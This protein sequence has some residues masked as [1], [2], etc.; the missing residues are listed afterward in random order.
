M[1]GPPGV[2]REFSGAGFNATLR[3]FGRIGQMMLDEGVA[4]GRRIVPAQWVRESTQPSGQRA[5][6][7]GGY[8]LQW[9]MAD[10]EGAYMAIG[11]QGQ[12]LYV[13][14]ASRT[15]IVK[16]SYFPPGDDAAEGETRAFFSAASA[17]K[18]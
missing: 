15:V 5:G 18:P 11:L 3:D 17:W 8:G 1:D 4:D 16:L 7:R 6:E 13:D 12:F 14:P 9:W 10:T 2:G